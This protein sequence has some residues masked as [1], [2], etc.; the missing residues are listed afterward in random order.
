VKAGESLLIDTEDAFSGQIR[1]AGDRRDKDRI[2]E[3]NP[4]NGPVVIEGAL[5]GDSISVRIESI[6]PRLGQCA[7]YL[8]PYDYM[9]AALGPN[10]DHQT[11][12]C[13]IEGSAILWDDTITIPYDPMIGVIGVT[14]EGPPPSTDEVGDH[15][16][17]LD[18]VEVGP[19]RTIHLPCMIPG[20]YLYI[21]DCHAAQGAG[22]L[23]AVALEMPARVRVQVGL[24]RSTS[25]PG[26]RIVSDDE[27]AAV[28]VCSSLEDSISEAYTRLALWIEADYGMDRWE[29]YALLT[30]VGSL[31]I[32][33]FRYR[34]VA[35][36][37]ARRYLG[38]LK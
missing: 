27:I 16:G 25:I 21:G 3:A 4:A 14:P 9:V 11:R 22:E 38:S 30:Q 37:I 23:S 20:G 26:P 10:V 13:S 12:V 35:A 18:L 28:A 1:A 32:G 7:T 31:S 6:E 8:W 19:G 34:A 17:N 15:G 33:Y 24:T 36:K 29:A 2:P 5:P